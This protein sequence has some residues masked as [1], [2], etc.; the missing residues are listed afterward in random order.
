MATIQK[1]STDV[2]NRIAA[3]EVVQR[4]SAALKELLE[5]AIDAECSRIQVLAAEGGLDVLQV[6]DD[7]SGIHREDL[8]LLCERYATSKLQ[9]FEDLQHVTSFGFRGEALASISYVA[10]VTV[11]TRRRPPTSVPTVSP[12]MPVS[13]SA[14]SSQV[15]WR[16][17]YLNGSLK[18]DPQPCAGNVG[19]TI[20]AEK[21][22]YNALVRRNSLRA[23]EEWG[24]I[25]DIVS[26]YALAYPQIGFTCQRDQSYGSSSSGGGGGT[27]GTAASGAQG[28]SGG[29]HFPPNSTTRQ[30]IRLSHGSRVAAS[31]RLVYAYEVGQASI[32]AEN[33]ADLPRHIKVEGEAEAPKTKTLSASGVQK[34]AA[35]EAR[36]FAQ[37]ERRANHVRSAVGPAG[38]GLFT[39]VGYTSD[40]TLAQRKPYLCLF[41][42]QRLVEST[43]IR[44]AIDGVYSGVLTG[45]NRPFTV[46]FLTVPTDRLDVNVHPTKKEVFLLDEEL[47]VARVSEVCRGAVLEA[48]AARQMDM[49]QMRHTTVLALKQLPLAD[50]SGGVDGDGSEL[51][52]SSSQHILE[53]LRDQHRRGAPMASPLT[54]SSLATSSRATAS[55]GPAAVVVAPCTMVRVEPQRG[56]LDRYF[57]QR[58][59]STGGDGGA[60]E[61]VVSK[62]ATTGS[63][64]IADPQKQGGRP[65]PF[66]SCPDTM[67]AT[68]V[69]TV[70][71]DAN[72]DRGGAGQHARVDV[73][74]DSAP[75]YAAPSW[76]AVMASLHRT[77]TVSPSNADEIGNHN[78]AGVVQSAI[79]N[80]SAASI[81]L[82][83]SEPGRDVPSMTETS[84]AQN[85]EMNVLTESPFQVSAFHPKRE[86]AADVDKEADDKDTS[87]SDDA[88]SDEEDRMREFK[89]HRRDVYERVEV[90]QRNTPSAVKAERKTTAFATEKENTAREVLLSGTDRPACETDASAL[91]ADRTAAEELESMTRLG[92]VVQAADL[93]RDEALAAARNVSTFAH[94][95]A[96]SEESDAEE[97]E[98]V[99]GRTARAGRGTEISSRK[100]ALVSVAEVEAP[101]ILSSVSIVME[102]ILANASPSAA[103]LTAQLAYVGAVDTRAFLAQVGTTLVWCD[104]MRLVRQVVFQRVF[105]R[106]GQPSL[107]A[108]SILEFDTPL[109]LSDL[110]ATALAFDA[111]HL[112]PPSAALLALMEDC[113]RDPARCTDGSRESQPLRRTGLTAEAVERM[114]GMTAGAWR[115]LLFQGPSTP[116]ATDDNKAFPP[117]T[118]MPVPMP[119]TCRYIRRLVRRLCRW[120]GLL[121]EYFFI[122]ITSDG[123]LVSVPYG[124]NR[125]WP[126]LL[127]A[128]P[129]TV[130]LLAEAVPYPGGTHAAV[131]TAPSP[132]PAPLQVALLQEDEVTSTEASAGATPAPTQTVVEAEADGVA[133][134]VACFTAVARHVADVL[135]GLQAP[136]PPATIQAAPRPSSAAS[137]GPETETSATA[138]ADETW[139]EQLV[140][141]GL[142]PCLKNAQLFRLP[143]RCLRDGTVQSMVSVES[144][145]K[146]FE[147][148]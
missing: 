63:P 35:Q 142:F 12:G 70:S 52:G 93:L 111:P 46:L 30:N 145:Y 137:E 96:S 144:L 139:R 120:R 103:A 126:P 68:T 122:H 89:R 129:L 77:T 3:G 115:R 100:T 82:L 4:P 9:S 25:V 43:A 146:V 26:R 78:R 17:Q 91:S 128:L 69:S 72:P 62:A 18:S 143:D 22:F 94:V 102:S 105:L 116:S 6:S 147:R 124:L 45:G 134:E 42:N 133:Q 5:N 28:G 53:K 51:S 141:H 32:A 47:V 114:G 15:A 21:L 92:A 59:A 140:Q 8:P 130:W 41:I 101:A 71:V 7:G 76:D 55:G 110:L 109:P 11:T 31:L 39:L 121:S 57:S 99:E 50:G 1:L 66:L 106:W 27:T 49:L 61:A 38:A 80:T 90:L 138:S 84:A 88:D 136:P 33:K 44:K 119:A 75:A 132:Q 48:A 54:S 24:R 123:L 64:V 127:R 56:A 87:S 108:P 98:E 2:I 135:Y 14:A 16:A 10:R 112:Q 118:S 23:S 104:T 79:L 107:P 117:P 20:R 83:D 65:E 86:R 34:N 74:K 85:T 29:V 13:S 113:D 58:L 125:H 60:A 37:M 36:V 81:V 97:G 148:C 67:D 40:P 19:T 73:E 131:N 95:I